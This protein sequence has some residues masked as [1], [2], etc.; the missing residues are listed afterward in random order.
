M[1][2]LPVK[3]VQS[4]QSKIT[5]IRSSLHSCILEHEDEIDL[6][7]TALISN[8][9]FLMVGSPGTAKS[10]MLEAMLKPITGAK[11]FPY[12]MGKFT[13]PDEIFGPV[14]ILAL[15]N[16][17]RRR[18]TSGK[19]PEAHLAFLDEFWKSSTAIANT[20]LRITNEKLFDNGDGDQ[21]VPLRVLVAGSNEYPQDGELGA[22]FDRFIIR[23]EVKYVQ[24]RENRRKLLAKM[25]HTPVI[26]CTLSLEEL[27]LACQEAMDL[28]GWDKVLDKMMEIVDTLIVEGIRPSDRRLPKTGSVVRAYAY[29][30]G[31]KEVSVN[32]LEVLSHMLW[33]DPAEQPKKCAEI[34]AKIANPIGLMINNLLGQVEEIMVSASHV[35]SIPKLQ[36][37]GKQ[38]TK[39]PPDTR[40][41]KAIQYV[42]E[43]MKER[44]ESVIRINR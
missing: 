12:V 32:H 38:L 11:Y 14:D 26:P 22:M 30:C 10:M 39:L 29:V 37:I 27:D 31:A 19:L 33:N 16:G 41:D 40:R 34:V 8:S 24:K 28:P 1:S 2:K 18:I 35:E 4:P 25:N 36:D 43:T 15:K 42:E 44:Y 13:E 6:G 5:A 3:Q 9:S 21:P 23:K 17:K 7:L 20:L